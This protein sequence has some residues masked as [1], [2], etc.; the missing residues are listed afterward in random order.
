MAAALGA[1]LL[2]AVVRPTG[3]AAVA[4]AVS[5]GAVAVMIVRPPRAEGL[6]WLVAV[7]LALANVPLWRTLVD[8]PPE[9]PPRFA[10]GRVYERAA[11]EPHPLPHALD[12][13]PAEAETRAIFR[14]AP[15]E[16]W[17]LTGALGGMPYAF[18]GDPDGIYFEGD[19]VVGKAIDALPWTERVPALRAAGVGYVVAP[20]TLPPPFEAM[21]VLG[22]DSGVTLHRLE[23]AA[24]SVRV[25]TRLF[26]AVTFDDVVPRQLRPDF[27]PRTD[28]IVI[29]SAPSHGMPLPS[30]VEVLEETRDARCVRVIAAPAPALVVWSRTYFGAWRARVD[31]QAAEVQVADGHLVGVPVSAGAHEVEIGWSSAPLIAGALVSLAA[32]AIVVLLRRR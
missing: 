18:D 26:T 10:G 29:E 22:R 23:G 5:V 30:S 16:L 4:A 7:T 15:R 19:R 9:P 2:V 17:A 1:V 14:R 6:A 8:V 21:T 25:A 11:A 28:A 24:P 31:G 12:W 27:D 3:I 32:L 13:P 20:A